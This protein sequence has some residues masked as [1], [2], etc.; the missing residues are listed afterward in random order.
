MIPCYFTTS[1]LLVLIARPL[2]AGYYILCVLTVM[3]DLLNLSDHKPGRNILDFLTDFSHPSDF[4]YASG[5]GFK[6]TFD[7]EMHR[8]YGWPHTHTY[9]H[10]TQQNQFGRLFSAFSLLFFCCCFTKLFFILATWHCVKNTQQVCSVVHENTY[11]AWY[12]TVCFFFV[13]SA[14]KEVNVPFFYSWKSSLSPSRSQ[15]RSLYCF[16]SHWGFV[17]AHSPEI[18]HHCTMKCTPPNS[19]HDTHIHRYV[20]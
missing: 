1:F 11:S 10:K 19:L 5:L 6:L 3:C 7:P 15:K 12:S 14:W 13:V 16:Q 4:C 2:T 20:R 8:E 9:T 18:Y 17:T